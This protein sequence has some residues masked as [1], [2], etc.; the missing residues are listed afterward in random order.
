LTGI[1]MYTDLAIRNPRLDSS[2]TGDLNVILKESQRC[3]KIV[4][5]LLDFSRESIPQKKPASLN[6]VMDAT[7][8][9]IG[10]QSLFQNIEIVREYQEDLPLIPFDENQM[11]QVFINILL[12]AGQSMEAGGRILIRTG[13]DNGSHAYLTITDTGAGIAEEDIEKIFDPFFT[14]KGDRGTGLGLSISFGI[15]ER[16]GGRI[17]VK[18]R[19]EDGT[20]F[21]I[22]LPVTPPQ[23]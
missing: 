17:E 16:H 11:E 20:T 21:T 2:I 1:L 6:S 13:A 12:N 5:G 19:K 8:D 23:D 10:H 7:L 22:T 15:I 18:S 4:R 14:T 3:A 9:L